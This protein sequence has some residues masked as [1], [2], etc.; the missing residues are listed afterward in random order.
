[1]GLIVLT[2]V[3]IESYV[4]YVFPTKVW[5]KHSEFV[6]Y[7][8]GGGD[9]VLTDLGDNGRML[10][11]QGEGKPEIPSDWSFQPAIL[12]ERYEF[13]QDGWKF[14]MLHHFGGNLYVFA[15]IKLA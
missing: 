14:K 10:L 5:E 2:G 13:Y 3:F 15:G 8:V 6:W 7:A 11:K 9:L 12:E 1:M 4:W